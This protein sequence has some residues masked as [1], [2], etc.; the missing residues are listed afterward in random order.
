MSNLYIT[1][2]R[3]FSPAK[4]EYLSAA[5][6]L[7]PYV[8]R[9]MELYEFYLAELEKGESRMQARTNTAEEFSLSED[10]ISKIVAQWGRID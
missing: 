7:K 8:L 9:N 1:I 6:L 4:L 3:K 2:K 5:G 10:N